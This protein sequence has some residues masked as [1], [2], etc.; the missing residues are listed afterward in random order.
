[1]I[2]SY[3]VVPTPEDYTPSGVIIDGAVYQLAGQPPVATSKGWGNMSWLFWWR[4]TNLI[5]VVDM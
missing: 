3:P 4:K 2:R 1:M 5:C